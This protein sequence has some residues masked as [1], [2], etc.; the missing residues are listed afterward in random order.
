M[1]RSSALFLLKL[2]EQRHLSQ[3]AIDEVV[4]G[5]R[6]LFCGVRDRIQAGVMAKLAE[7]GINLDSIN[8]LDDVFTEVTDPFD[9]IETCYRQ[10]KYY[11][12]D[13]GLIV[14]CTCAL[15]NSQLLVMCVL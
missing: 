6:S 2:K 3:V 10:E 5:S 7:S 8:G 15:P 9:G 11:R 13:L 12:E 14:S 1:R 4:E